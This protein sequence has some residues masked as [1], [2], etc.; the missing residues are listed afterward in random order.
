L[1]IKKIGAF[2]RNR[3]LTEISEIEKD[4][5]Y[6]A[7]QYRD[8]LAQLATTLFTT[9]IILAAAV[10]IFVQQA[11]NRSMTFLAF[12]GSWLFVSRIS[13]WALWKSH[14]NRIRRLDD[15]TSRSSKLKAG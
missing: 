10:Y 8:K 11:N 7:A 1:S 4:W 2:L 12:F 14:Q 13:N 9:L 15:L 5:E 6:F 3:S